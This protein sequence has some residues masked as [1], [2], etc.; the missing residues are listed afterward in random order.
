MDAYKRGSFTVINWQARPGFKDSFLDPRASRF[1]PVVFAPEAV[2]PVAFASEA[3][4]PVAFVPETVWPVAFADIYRSF[5]ADV[6][7][8][9]RIFADVCRLNF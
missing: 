6:C 9:L 2:G 7:G 4:A 3:I 8:C 1:A 5:F